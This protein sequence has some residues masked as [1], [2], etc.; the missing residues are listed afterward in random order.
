MDHFDEMAWVDFARSLVP[1]DTRLAM[2]HHLDD[3]CKECLVTMETWQSIF[4][5]AKGEGALTPP[6][7]AIRVVKSFADPAQ[8]SPGVRLVF[9]SN[10]QPAAAGIRGTMAARQLLYQTDDYYVD[11]RLEPGGDSDRACLVGQVMDRSGKDTA[12]HGVSVRLKAG[13][14]PLAETT[15]NQFGEFQ[16]DFAAG[17]NLSVSIVRERQVD[18]LLPL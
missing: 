18:I 12:G 2:Q 8:P 4:A 17:G 10:L 6:A 14:L 9:D 13:N 7:D 1:E 3:G 15:V 5:V 11:L 16:F